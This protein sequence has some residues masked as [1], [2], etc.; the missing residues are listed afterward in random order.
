MK[1]RTSIFLLF[2]NCRN[3]YNKII[4]SFNLDKILKIRNCLKYICFKLSK[5][6]K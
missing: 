6:I 1:I 3:I 2:W 4:L 5:K